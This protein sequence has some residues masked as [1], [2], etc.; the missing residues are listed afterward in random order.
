MGQLPGENLGLSAIAK[1]LVVNFNTGVT[2]SLGNVGDAGDVYLPCPP[3]CN[4]YS[5]SSYRNFQLPT[6]LVNMTQNAGG[7]WD[8]CNFWDT[9]CYMEGGGVNP[10]PITYPNQA[11]PD[12]GYIGAY[13]TQNGGLYT[14]ST[15]RCSTCGTELTFGGGSVRQTVHGNYYI[16]IYNVMVPQYTSFCDSILL[17]IRVNEQQVVC[18]SSRYGTLNTHDYTV[19]KYY[20]PTTVST[21]GAEYRVECNVTYGSC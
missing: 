17:E 6:A 5:M 9:F 12:F 3:L 2:S 4:Q 7:I 20:L 11:D 1:E 14:Y 10:K 16:T 15:E 13:W 8:G 21:G 18:A 19:L